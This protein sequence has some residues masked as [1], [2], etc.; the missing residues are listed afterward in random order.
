M[1][2]KGIDPD[3]QLSVWEKAG[4]AGGI[5]VGVTPSDLSERLELLKDNENIRRSSGLFP[6]GSELP[7]REQLLKLLEEQLADGLADAVGETGI[8]LHWNYGT[9]EIQKYLFAEQVRLADKYRLPVIV[10][11]READAEVETVLKKIAPARG[12]IM[13]CFSSTYAAAKKWLDY[14]FLIS[15][16]GNVT[17]P[18]SEAV[19]EAAKRLPAEAVLAE[20]DSPHLAPQGFRGK[21]NSPALLVHTY[22]LL[23][24][25]KGIPVNRFREQVRKNY[26]ELFS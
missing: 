17:Y 25:L 9:P 10:H 22:R 13:H 26:E 5:D 21:P 7:G 2:K 8:D 6:G 18:K 16:A 20:T 11:N 1:N 14:G 23:A 12:G 15:F 3:E 24:E 19:R 4:F